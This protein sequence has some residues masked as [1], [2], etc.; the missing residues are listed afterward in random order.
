MHNSTANHP[1]LPITIMLGE[2]IADVTAPAH[3]LNQPIRSQL[4]R[5][6]DQLMLELGVPGV[7]NVELG[8]CSTHRQERR[9]CVM[10]AGR[11]ARYSD[12]L[13]ERA[14]SYAMDVPLGVAS[15][16]EMTAWFQQQVAAAP[17][18]SALADLVAALASEIIEQA[19]SILLGPAQL[20]AYYAVLRSLPSQTDPAPRLPIE[21][22]DRVARDLLDQK[23]GIGN[24]QVIAD[25]ITN[26]LNLGRAIHE[27]CEEAIAA[28]RPLHATIYIAA[29]LLRR[30]TMTSV[31]PTSVTF[32][33]MRDGLFYELGARLPNLMFETQDDLRPNS[34]ALRINDV[35]TLPKVSIGPDQLLVN[36]RPDELQD[37]G[38]HAIGA[39]QPYSGSRAAI[40]DVADL[41]AT[42]ATG[43]TTYD[44][45]EYLVLCISGEMRRNAA[46]LFD[47]D[48]CEWM[49]NFLESAFPELVKAVRARYTTE[50]ITRTL[51]ALIAEDI[52]I[53]N[54]RAIMEAMLDF[55]FIVTDPAKYIVFDDRLPVV[56]AAA[57]DAGADVR[58]LVDFVRM[59][60]KRP[61]SH[62]Y[63]RG[64]N[65]LTVYLLDPSMEREFSAPLSVDR[66]QALLNTIRENVGTPGTDAPAILTGVDVRAAVRRLIATEYPQLPVLAYQELAPELNIQPI[67]RIQ[68]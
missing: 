8:V 66:E 41:E 57:A 42:S 29:D 2:P 24:T 68:V 22:V 38:I 28:L 56:D 55:D 30:L 1:T 34:F 3:P 23:I 21:M 27:I 32:A 10:I 47:R 5:V 44:A 31:G 65:T 63:T 45:W 48:D 51:R 14:T 53:R 20:E 52:S 17:G 26:G 33:T 12:A 7:V 11:E 62:K 40:V 60:L 61:I 50:Q 37:R 19:P 18:E 64:S 4:A 39:T 16:Q 15:D 9:I 36:S 49:L 25:I 13:L 58:P 46:V 35:V 67:A 6:L 59:C 43:A 54:A